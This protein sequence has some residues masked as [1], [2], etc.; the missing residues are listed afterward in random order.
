MVKKYDVIII[1][2]GIGGLTAAAILSKK[3]KRVLVVEKNPM[4]GGYAVSFTRKG[5][6]FNVSMHLLNGYEKTGF[7]CATLKKYN[8]LNIDNFKKTKHI[9]R[10]IWPGFNF[11]VRQNGI[12]EYVNVLAKH[13]PKEKDNILKFFSVVKE[14][15]TVFKNRNNLTDIITQWKRYSDKSFE[16]VAS[17]FI[18]NHK[19]IATISQLCWILGLPPGT[20]DFVNFSYILYDIIGNGSYYYKGGGKAIINDLVSCIRKNGGHLLVNKEAKKILAKN[21]RATGVVLNNQEVFY[22]DS[23]ISNIDARRT[24]CDMVDRKQLPKQFPEKI[25]EISQA[26]S[27]F[28]VYIGLKCNLKDYGIND[29]IIFINQDFNLN[30]QYKASL[31][32]DFKKVPIIVAISSNP[33]F[34]YVPKDK[35]AVCIFT[36]AG[37]DF[38]KRLNK[39][40]YKETK[41]ILARVLIRRVEKVIPNLS[42][43]IEVEEVSTPLTM[44]RYTGNYKGAMCGWEHSYAQPPQMLPEQITPIENLYLAGHWTHLGAGISRAMYSGM[45]AAEKILS[46]SEP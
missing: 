10:S 45:T 24:F 21:K 41:K 17:G 11:L 3:G 29:R 38:W 16:S 23:I 8:I 30:A 14:T 31:T 9:Y 25:A 37:Y 2:S 5:F 39:I 20:V 1:G 13:F 18:K 19:L 15:H 35:T 7:I 44:G 6:E 12:K 46:K 36:L 27:A 28:Q 34:G 40:K 33:E 42:D 22:A 32:N 43:F 26:I 4:P